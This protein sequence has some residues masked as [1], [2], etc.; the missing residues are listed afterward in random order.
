[1]K[2]LHYLYPCVR[3]HL[4]A[5]GINCTH[6]IDPCNRWSHQCSCATWKVYVQRRTELA[7]IPLDIWCHTLG[8]RSFQLSDEPYTQC[9]QSQLHIPLHDPLYHGWW[10]AEVHGWAG[11]ES[12]SAHTVNVTLR[13]SYAHGWA[14]MTD[15][16]PERPITSEDVQRL[17]DVQ[18]NSVGLLQLR[19]WRD[20]YV[21]RG[22]PLSSPVALLLTFPLTM[23]HVIVEYGIIPCTVASML[24]RPLR[25]HI[26][27][28]EK[29]L[30]FLDLFQE[31]SFL[32]PSHF[33]LELVFVVR[34]DMLPPSLREL[35]RGYSFSL[36]DQ[37][38][39]F[40]V[41]G[42]YGDSLHPDFDC[43]TGPPD[44]ILAYNAGL[45]AHESWRSVLYYLYSHSGVVGVF[46]DYNEFSGIQ[47]ASLG[48]R[49]SRMSLR[50]NPFRQPRAMPVYSMNLP[51][52]C[53][54]FLYVFNEQPEV[55]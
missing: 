33:V 20:Y 32:L 12:T 37:L 4:C 47:C 41:S 42:T 17:Q 49:H 21:L 11:G 45:F 35:P 6:S 22:I 8:T 38:R 55:D 26:V 16:P 46:T 3:I 43:G 18:R 5:N 27:G 29:E 40:I 44:M 51:Q 39:M 25:I 50:V 2:H 28:T 48:G 9:L 30:H 54:G 19:H 1:M 15:I 13:Q 53:N 14:P 24:Q 23:Y 7:E 52:C 34:H 36:G 31:V 10:R